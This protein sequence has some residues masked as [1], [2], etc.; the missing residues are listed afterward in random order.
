MESF[1][2]GPN[3]VL[4]Q[5]V[6][7]VNNLSG[8]IWFNPNR[9]KKRSFFGK[10]KIFIRLPPLKNPKAPFP[11]KIPNSKMKAPF[12]HGG[13]LTKE[14]KPRKKNGLGKKKNDPPNPNS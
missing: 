6:V 4:S 11:L 14:N 7:K 8:K 5:L 3:S 10:P 9:K 13:D 2:F 1:L 12:L